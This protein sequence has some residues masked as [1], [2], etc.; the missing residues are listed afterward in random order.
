MNSFNFSTSL[1]TRDLAL[2]LTV[3]N[4][5][6]CP[7][8]L[9]ATLS[10]SNKFIN[11]EKLVILPYFLALLL[12]TGQRPMILRAKKSVA[13]F[14]LKANSPLG[15]VVTLRKDSLKSFFE[16]S[17]LSI[18]PKLQA[19]TELNFASFQTNRVDFSLDSFLKC[20]EIQPNTELFDFLE[21]CSCTFETTGKSVP[22]TQLFMSGFQFPVFKKTK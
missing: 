14:Q 5:Y 4:A 1:I 2:K 6:E 9:K 8:L 3:K 20:V 21:G 13:T 16:K 17:C 22:V 12:W 18:F 19:L 15:C 11:A 10:L 7:K